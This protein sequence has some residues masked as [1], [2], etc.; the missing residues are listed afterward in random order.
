M[1]TFQWTRVYCS[2]IDIAHVYSISFR[3]IDAEV[4][5]RRCALR[6]DFNQSTLEGD[7]SCKNI[8]VLN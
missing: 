4:F 6:D 1:C 2:F 5:R 3:Y 7:V 8:L